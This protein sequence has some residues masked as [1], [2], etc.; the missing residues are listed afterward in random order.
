MRGAF[1]LKISFIFLVLSSVMSLAAAQAAVQC[2]LVDKAG[3]PVDGSV[4]NGDGTVTCTYVDAGACT[5]F[6]A[7]GE[8]D[9]GSS[10]CPA[11]IPQ[12]VSGSIAAASSS[13]SMTVSSTSS[14]VAI[15]LLPASR[16]P[17]P[18]LT[19]TTTSSSSSTNTVAVTSTVTSS[20]GSSTS[21]LTTVFSTSFSQS[22]TSAANAPSDTTSSSAP[23]KSNSAISVF[24]QGSVSSVVGIMMAVVAA[25]RA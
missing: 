5:Y 19:T 4:N 3:S 8:N 18:P 14:V 10:D 1:N 2:T 7:N 13:T 25:Y 21:G 20:S 11:G 24:A 23:T 17:P 12:T 6:A 9:S 22:I 16:T 15:L